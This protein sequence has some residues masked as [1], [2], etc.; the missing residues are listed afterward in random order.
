M[1][2]DPRR[3][4]TVHFPVEMDDGTVSVFTGFRVQHNLSRGPAKGGIRYRP[5]VTSDGGFPSRFHIFSPLDFR[6]VAYSHGLSTPF[7]ATRLTRV[8]RKV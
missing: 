8:S 2:R 5:D 6:G 4:L 1:L 7:R 3:E